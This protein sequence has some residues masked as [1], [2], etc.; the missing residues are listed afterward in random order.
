MIEY[1][2]TFLEALSMKPKTKFVGVVFGIVLLCLKPFLIQYNMNWFYNKF[3]WI[4]ILITLFFA[5]SLTIEVIIEV[6][7]WSKN[8]YN[9]KDI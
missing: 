5:A 4:I 7:E 8:K 3:S 9:T 2:K 6:C 1:L